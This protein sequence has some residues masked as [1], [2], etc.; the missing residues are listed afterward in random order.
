MKKILTLLLLLTIVFTSTIQA[1]KDE[2]AAAAKQAEASAMEGWE[3]Y[4]AV[5]EMHNMLAKADG[6]WKE[7]IQFWQGPGSEPQKNSTSCTNKM[8]LGGRYQE[9]THS[10]IVMGMPFEGKGLVGYDNIKKVFMSTWADN[11]GTGIM[12]VE[13]PYNEKTQSIM[14]HGMMMDPISGKELKVR[15]LFTFVNDSHQK[16]E[17]FVTQNGSEHKSMEIN[18]HR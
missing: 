12:Y 10:G 14:M 7:E 17:M 16:L 15:E 18:Y 6:E 3:K 1:Q 2:K 8:I 9:S 5:G 11:M 13:G 4:M